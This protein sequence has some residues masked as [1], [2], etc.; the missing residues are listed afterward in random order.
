MKNSKKN[1]RR[2]FLK[3]LTGTAVLA[4]TAPQWLIG[5]PS[6][7]TMIL[8]K[9][10]HHV[11]ANDNIQIG[12]IGMGIMGFSNCN[13]AVMIPGVKL[14][15]A[16]D[17]YDGRLKRTKEIFGEEVITTRDYKEIL[18]RP[19]ID[20]VIIST[21]DHW[22]DRISIEAMKKGKDVYCEKPVVQKLEEGAAVIKTEKNTKKVFQVGSQGVSSILNLKAKQLYEEGAI[23]EIILL[24]AFMDRQSAISAW[25]YSI[26]TDA[27]EKT[28]DWNRFL[29]DTKKIPFDPVRFFRWRNYRDYG[30]GV[31]GDLFVHLFT[32]LHALTSSN[33]PN[34]IYAT[35]GLRY[36]KDGREVPDVFLGLYDYPETDS[37][38]AFNVQMRVNFIDGSGGDGLMR[39]VGT[40]GVIECGN[41]IKLRRNKIP[42][43]PGYGGWDSFDTF[44]EAAQRDFVKWYKEKYPDTKPQVKEPELTEYKLPEGYNA[45]YEHHWNFYNSIRTGQKVVEDAEY[46]FRAAAPAL[47]SNIS[48]F[49]KRIVKWDPI[50]MKMV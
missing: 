6:K 21:P 30:T 15:A 14:V 11:S 31:A 22:H 10:D 5:K 19:D 17:L 12:A 1:L 4:S 3:K 36:W 42:Q 38:P 43:N 7:D 41:S 33:G 2:A 46:A 9:K 48:Y 26:P 20:A 44:T 32:G 45:D 24:E 8:K 47:A 40:E 28:I 50:R 35:G 29:G 25:Q 49:E 23:G 34:T 27:S 39:I 37:H 13:T 18:D 16:C